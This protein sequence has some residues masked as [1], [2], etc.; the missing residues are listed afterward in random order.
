MSVLEFK[1][2]SA[3]LI[4]ETAKQITAESNAAYHNQKLAEGLVSSVE[5]F[6]QLW[7]DVEAL[8]DKFNVEG[9]DCKGIDHAQDYARVRLSELLAGMK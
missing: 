2:S 4:K 3:S 5:S 1:P 9:W 7:G 6:V 8:R